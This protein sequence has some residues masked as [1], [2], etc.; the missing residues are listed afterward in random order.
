MTPEQF[1]ICKD[2]HL[3]L[4]RVKVKDE[5]IA[6]TIDY[7]FNGI[8]QK[9]AYDRR[10]VDVLLKKVNERYDSLIAWSKVKSV[11]EFI[12]IYNK[13]NLRN[14]SDSA[15]I[16][17]FEVINGSE[18]YSSTIKHKINYRCVLVLVPRLE[19]W[20]EYSKRLIEAL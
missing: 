20:N 6:N 8:K 19:R 15:F 12:K 5:N 14:P 11:K 16:S 13:N 18:I 7:L 9:K 10:A 3:E 17:A 4:I 1:N 2:F